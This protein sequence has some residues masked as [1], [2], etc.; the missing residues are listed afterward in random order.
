MNYK[1]MS[2][3]EAIAINKLL[4]RQVE[5]IQHGYVPSLAELM[6]FIDKRLTEQF[7]ALESVKKQH[8]EVIRLI[9]R[10]EKA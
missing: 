4:Q 5:E 9:Q 6:D 2:L 3:D 8:D 1:M 10:G 7:A